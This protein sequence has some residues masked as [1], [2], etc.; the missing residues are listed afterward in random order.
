MGHEEG[1]SRTTLGE[2]PKIGLTKIYGFV[3]SP[4]LDQTTSQKIIQRHEDETYRQ[5]LIQMLRE[6]GN[7]K[8]LSRRITRSKYC[9]ISKPLRFFNAACG[10]I[11]TLNHFLLHNKYLA[12]HSAP[13]QY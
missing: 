1:P 3:L 10:R 8:F 9:Y 12:L 2:L 11:R 7:M 4:I 13:H 5:K 6:Q